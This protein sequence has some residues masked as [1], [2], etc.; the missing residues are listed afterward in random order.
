MS[1]LLVLGITIIA[2]YFIIFARNVK[3]SIITFF[4]GIL[5][6]ILKPVEGLEFEN[7]GRIVSFETLGILLGMMIIVEI[8]KESG[9]FTFA[10]VNAIKL[11]RYKFWIVL[12]M[13]MVLVTFFSAFLD[14]LITIMLMAPIIFLVAD[15]I[16][17]NPTPLILLTITIDNIGGMSTLIGSPLNIVLG[18]IG[19][20]HFTKFLNVM[21][22]IT[23]LSFISVI[24]MFKINNKVD[25]K[26][27]NE[28]LK[29]LSDMDPEKAIENKSL[30]YKGLTVFLIVLT[31]FMF[32]SLIKIDLALIAMAGALVLMLLTQKDF[33]SMSKDLDWDTMFFYGGLFTIAFSLEEIGVTQA[34]ANVFNPLMATPFLLMV[35]IMWLSA[36]V[37]P[38]L[39]AVPGTLILAPVIKLLVLHGAPYELWY[40]Y[41]IGANL[42]TNL[43]P[44]GA[45]QNIVGVSLLEKNYNQTI[46]FGEYMK[47]S[48]FSVLIPLILGTIY[49]FFI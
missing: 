24:I 11:S 36:F 8:L 21:L 15:T 3:K 17:M 40:A 44:L 31:G 43:T 29:K 49:L 33:E 4:F 18:S 26:V 12:T 41:A 22:P 32:H 20:L 30:M 2:Y 27:F 10:A 46:T 1:E 6:F 37:I 23:I 39:S 14:N 16:E 38:F 13:L 42:G 34:I 19:D 28:R 7:I 9:F 35:V 5:L 47:K 45:V 25:S 48:F